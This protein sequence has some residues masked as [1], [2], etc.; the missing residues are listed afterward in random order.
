MIPG[1]YG[2]RNEL[3]VDVSRLPRIDVAHNGA[4]V[5]VPVIR[6]KLHGHRGISAYHPEM[7]EFVVMDEPYF[8]YPVSCGTEAQALGVMETFA[9]SQA[10]QHPSDPRQVVFTILPTHGILIAEKWVPDTRPFQTIWEYFDRGYLVL[11]THVP[12]GPM[13]YVEDTG[14]FVLKSPHE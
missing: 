7:V 13:A 9:R 11:D 14:H 8:N 10:L 4:R 6:S 1:L 2:N 3:Q 5:E 12:Q